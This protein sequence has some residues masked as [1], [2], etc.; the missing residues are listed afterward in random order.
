MDSYTDFYQVNGP[1]YDLG[2]V[3]L[4]LNKSGSSELIHIDI[5]I[6]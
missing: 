4:L 2:Q 5:W 6:R 1:I 3:N